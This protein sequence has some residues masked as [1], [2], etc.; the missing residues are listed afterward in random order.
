MTGIRR[1]HEPGYRRCGGS[2]IGYEDGGGKA[3]TIGY[4]SF[5]MDILCSDGMNANSWNRP[6]PPQG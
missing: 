5:A 4:D 6:D 2:E 3:E 1:V